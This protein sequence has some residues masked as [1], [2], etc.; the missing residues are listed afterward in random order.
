[1]PWGSKTKAGPQA[2][3]QTMTLSGNLWPGESAWKL[4]IELSPAPNVPPD[5]L[6]TLTDLPV[7][8][9]GSALPLSQSTNMG[10]FSIRLQRVETKKPS[11][12][13]KNSATLPVTISYNAEGL[14]EDCHLSLVK[15]SDEHGRKVQINGSR[16][17][18]RWG[19]S[20]DLAVPTNATRLNCAFGLRKS[21]FVE[22]IAK[23]RTP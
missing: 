2:V 6:A 8:P 16:E 20:F 21:R 12:K 11:A 18:S 19:D 17:L 22:F 4:R 15:V 1:V 3:T 13:A 9:E 10:Q 14:P 23:P 5:E 7:P